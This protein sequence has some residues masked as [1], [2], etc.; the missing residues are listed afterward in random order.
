MSYY[1]SRRVLK[2]FL[3]F[4]R[5]STA[6]IFRV[7]ESFLG[8]AEEYCRKEF[9]NYV[10][11]LE[12]PIRFVSLQVLRLLTSFVGLLDQNYLQPFYVTL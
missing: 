10:R 1:D 11:R 12:S 5:E 4:Q 7:T 8:G 3:T 9:F 6:Y 2:I